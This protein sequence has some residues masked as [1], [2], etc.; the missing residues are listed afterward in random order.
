MV[1]RDGA[2]IGLEIALQSVEVG[3]CALAA[4]EP[5]QHQPAGGV[6]DKDQQRAFFAALLKPAMLA[7]VDLDQLTERFPAQTGLMEAPTLFARKPD[8]GFG[9]PA[10]QRL[11]RNP[12]TIT[13]GELLGRERR[14]EVLV[15]LANQRD[16]VSA[17][18]GGDL[19]VG[20][21]AA[22]SVCECRATLGPQSGQQAMRLPHADPQNRGGRADRPLASHDLR[23]NPYP[24]YVAFAHRYPAHGQPP[25]WPRRPGRLTFLLWSAGRPA[26]SRW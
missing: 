1:E 18:A 2:A 23:Q 5:E 11:A 13:L 7:A 4:D 19:V 9:H 22:S 20:R 6:I 12:K 21:A 10:A 15:L 3:S 16:R 26:R 17:N 24:L 25:H 14:A 8:P